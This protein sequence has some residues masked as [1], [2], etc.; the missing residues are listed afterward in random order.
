MGIESFRIVALAAPGSVEAAL[1]KIQAEIFSRFGLASAHA[2]PPVIPVAF[3][4][5]NTSPRGLLGSLNES[6]HAP[7]SV[8]AGDSEWEAEYLYVGVGSGGAWSALRARTLETCGGEPIRLFPIREGF[9][10]GCGDA[11]PAQRDAIR[12][13]VP[14]AAFSSGDLVLLSIETPSGHGAWWQ[15]LY[16]EIVEQRP[17]RGRRDR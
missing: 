3:L 5:S 4:P 1:G 14:P 12:P 15:E 6:V 9:F 11:T 16:W 17:L 7:W 10:M 2:L 13:A 8:R